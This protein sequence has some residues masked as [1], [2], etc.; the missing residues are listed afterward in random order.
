MCIRDSLWTEDATIQSMIDLAVDFSAKTFN[1]EQARDLV[2][3]LE[4]N[5]TED[6]STFG[7][8]SIRSSFSQLTW[9]RLKMQPMGEVQ[10]KLKEL[11]GIMCSVQLNFLASREGEEG[12]MET[13]EV[14]E[15]FTMK[16]NELRTYLMDY[17]REVNQVFQGERTD[18]S[19]KRILLGLSLIHI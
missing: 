3:Y 8:T 11:D 17:E 14:E 15:N 6:N 9:G 4:T 19:G 7:K 5:A 2:T 12:I 18:Y 10:V 1:Y 16:W 13:Y